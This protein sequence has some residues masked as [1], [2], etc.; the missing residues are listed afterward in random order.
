MTS[1]A[2]APGRVNTEMQASLRADGNGVMDDAVYKTFTD[3]FE[4]GQLLKP[5]QPGN[6]IADFVAKPSKELSGK[7]LR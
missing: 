1:I 4:Q 7:V 3:A 6:V 5:E 2:V